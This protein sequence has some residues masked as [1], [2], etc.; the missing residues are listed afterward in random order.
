[1]TR[2][3]NW[4][5]ALAAWA[6]SLIGRTWE[7]GV[8]DCVTVVRQ[9]IALVTG[10]DPWPFVPTW[11]TSVG[12]LRAVEEHGGVRGIL[13]QVADPISARAWTIGD[14]LHV[15]ADEDEIDA[16]S[17]CLRDRVLF[18]HPAQPI[19]A[20]PVMRAHRQAPVG[21]LQFWRLR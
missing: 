19:A 18:V 21:Q 12:M 15:P 4:D 14:L 10:S 6:H 2:P 5:L 11:D 20:V 7:W 16:V 13:A 1:M 8:T 3:A 17:V 9:A